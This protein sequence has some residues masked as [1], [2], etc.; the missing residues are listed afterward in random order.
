MINNSEELEAWLRKQPREVSVVFAARAALRILPVV[1]LEKRE[2]YIRDLVLPVFRATAISWAAAKYPA[3]EKEL[4]TACRAAAAALV[5]Q[6]TGSTWGSG[7]AA[8]A[9]R[10]AEYAAVVAIRDTASADAANAAVAAVDA[11]AAFGAGLSLGFNLDL[12]TAFGA[13]PV[14]DAF[15]AAFSIDATRVEKGAAAS[16]I[17]GS[18]LWPLHILQPEPLQSL[19]QDLKAALLASKQ[20]WQVWT[21]WID[22]RVASYVRDEERELAYVRIEEALWAQARQS[23]TRRSKSGSRSK[24]LHR[25]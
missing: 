11:L 21:I 3:R 13:N 15:W 10:A 4:A 16:D 8:A 2:T 1:Q 5:A 19:W 22:D 12:A 7:Y 18:M 17:A 20:N 6:S 25:R 23:S 24:S 14:V 9:S